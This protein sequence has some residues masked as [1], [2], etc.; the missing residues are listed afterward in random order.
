MIS[1][2]WNA[3]ILKMS[4]PIE[5][6]DTCNEKLNRYR[7]CKILKSI[8]TFDLKFVIV[9]LAFRPIA[10]KKFIERMVNNI[11]DWAQGRLHIVKFCVQ[12][13]EVW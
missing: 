13:V 11:D 9:L 5:A 7:T 2:K 8:P 10:D 6:W 3:K 4:V 12:E 1:D